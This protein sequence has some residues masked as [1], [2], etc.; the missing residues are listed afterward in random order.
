MGQEFLE[1]QNPGRFRVADG[2]E[3]RDDVRVVPSHQRC[4]RLLIHTSCCERPGRV[5]LAGS[6]DSCDKR[7]AFTILILADINGD[8]RGGLWTD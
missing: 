5:G 7:R 2:S 4:S 1:V 8:G 3:A 6:S